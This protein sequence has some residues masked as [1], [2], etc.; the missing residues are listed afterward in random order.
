V[1]E[2]NK[3]GRP[4]Q[5]SARKA[6]LAVAQYKGAGG[7]YVGAKKA[8]NSL[9]RWTRQNWHTKSG[10]PSSETGERYLPDKAIKALTSAEY[11]ATTRA[12]RQATAQGRQF[13]R[14]PARIAAKTAAYRTNHRS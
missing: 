11:G 4:G 13:S 7:G 1:K 12:K 9:A 3:G 8:D 10:R 14:Q 5:W 6:Q 2:G